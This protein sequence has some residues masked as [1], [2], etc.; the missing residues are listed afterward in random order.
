MN[1]FGCLYKNR[2]KGE[3]KV[4]EDL[5]IFESKENDISIN[6][7]RGQPWSSFI[8]QSDSSIFF[9]FSWQQ[10]DINNNSTR[11]RRRAA[12][13]DKEKFLNFRLFIFDSIE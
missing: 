13:W 4:K 3:L 6:T 8:L 1:L 2:V 5:K 9:P 12:A 10:T 7:R 11:R